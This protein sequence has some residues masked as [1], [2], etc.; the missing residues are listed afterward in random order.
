MGSSSS[1]SSNS[2]DSLN[3]LKFGQK[4][5][6]EDVGVGVPAKSGGGSSLAGAAGDGIG[7]P[8]TT[9]PKKGRSGVIQG[10]LP[11]RCQGLSRGFVSSV[12]GSISFL[13]LTKGKRSCR[14]RLA[15]HNERRRKLPSGSLLSRHGR[16]SSSIFEN[17]SRAGSFL[18]DFTTY[19]KLTGK[20]S[21]PTTRASERVVLDSQPTTMGKFL[22]H[23]WQSS[24]PWGSRNRPSSLGVNNL[25]NA[26]GVPMVQPTAHH[27]AASTHFSSTPWGFK[28]NEASNS[29]HQ[30]P[31]DLGLAQISQPANG[32]YPG[33]LELAQQSG[34]QYAELEHSRAYDSSTQYVHWL[35]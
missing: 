26:D 32:H 3:G 25:L 20:D 21:W 4:I 34:R 28:G 5:Y 22:P 29:L 18:M 24:S 8:P 7:P 30:M 35:L 16:L 19:P 14:R 13:N 33:E 11:P 10:G 12:A 31:H 27:G 1:S 23:L 15:G 6:F 17:N 9:P 2:S